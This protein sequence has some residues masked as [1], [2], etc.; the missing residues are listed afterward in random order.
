[1][2]TI[3]LVEDD[4]FLIDIYTTK[5]KEAGFEMSVAEDGE[6]ALRKIQEEKPDLLLL[7]IVLPRIDGWEMLEKIKNQNLKGFKIVV[8]S[9]LGQKDDIEKG[10]KLG[11]DRYLV[12]AHLTPS[13]VVEEIQTILANTPLS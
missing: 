11:A 4:P 6:E 9:N 2:K 3:L 10:I 5:F 8:L 1:M 7:D 13:E 12:K